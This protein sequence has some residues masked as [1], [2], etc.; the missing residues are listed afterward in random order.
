MPLGIGPRT[1]RGDGG[2]PSAVPGA[3]RPRFS[4]EKMKTTH[5]LSKSGASRGVA[6][7]VPLSVPGLRIKGEIDFLKAW[8]LM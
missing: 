3:G 8:S 4:A 6:G 1:R 2:P 7:I 5:V